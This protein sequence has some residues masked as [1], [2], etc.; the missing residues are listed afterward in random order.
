MV[1]AAVILAA[2]KGVRMRSAY[3]KVV[4]KVSEPAMIQHVVHAVQAAGITEIYVVVGH[5]REHV[6]ESLSGFEVE[7]IVQEQQ[8]GT[9]HALKQAE[10]GIKNH[11]DRVLVLS[12]DTPLI[13]AAPDKPACLAYR[14]QCRSYGSVGQG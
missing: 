8:L 10:S 14:E 3:P 9:G 5:G 1:N 2:G 13:R 7:F 12:G 4:H 11:V 6:I